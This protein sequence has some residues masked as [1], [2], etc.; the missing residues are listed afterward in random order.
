MDGSMAPRLLH[1]V[2]NGPG[3]WQCTTLLGE[4]LKLAWS[5]SSLSPA[6]LAHS[7]WEAARHPR[8]G[9]ETSPCPMGSARFY[10]TFL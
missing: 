2:P 10:P 4:E 3:P 6:L 8:T 9:R 5:K 7:L 1:S